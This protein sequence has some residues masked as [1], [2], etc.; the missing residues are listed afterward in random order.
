MVLVIYA[1]LAE[2]NINE[3]FAAALVPG[4]LA[5]F[6]YMLAISL[7]VRFFLTVHRAR[8][9]HPAASAGVR[10]WMYGQERRSLS[11]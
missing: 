8:Q 11:W 1:I 2:Q 7:Y 9:K 10:C 6:S 5:V 4:L 3:M